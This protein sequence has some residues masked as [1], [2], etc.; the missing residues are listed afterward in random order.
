MSAE[1]PL[2]ELQIDKSKADPG[3]EQFFVG[4]VKVQMVHRPEPAAGDF[5]VVAVAFDRGARTR[6]HTHTH[7][8]FLY[9]VEGD[10]FVH[11][12]GADEQRVSPGTIMVV[13]SGIL[14]MH[15]ATGD[16]PCLHLAMRPAG[17]GSE[18]EFD[19]LPSGWDRWTIK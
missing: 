10:G 8:Q 2:P 14:H 6:P 17:A 13:P 5:E 7:D 16:G 12:A 4:D 19:D 1:R 9:F 3:P 15:G 11:I 18:W